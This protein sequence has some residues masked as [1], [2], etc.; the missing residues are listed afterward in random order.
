MGPKNV[1]MGNQADPTMLP[2][3]Q[4]DDSQFQELQKTARFSK[5]AEFKALKSYIEERMAFYATYL[6][7]GD[8]P[9]AEKEMD[10]AQIGENWRVANLIN[11]EFK[12]LLYIYEN[13]ADMV[14]EEMARRTAVKARQEDLNDGIA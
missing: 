1:I 14:K 10:N 2:E 11:G 4:V 9:A 7:R 5:S 8:N 12:Q 6:P 13:A 3:T